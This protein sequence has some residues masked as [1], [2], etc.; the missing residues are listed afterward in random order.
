[1]VGTDEM[2]I[3]RLSTVQARRSGLIDDSQKM[4]IAKSRLDQNSLPEGL[5]LRIFSKGGI[6]LLMD[7]F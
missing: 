2:V 4:S 7:K 5:I 3:E 1:L 6:S